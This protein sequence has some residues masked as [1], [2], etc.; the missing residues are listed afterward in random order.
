MICDVARLLSDGLIFF[1]NLFICYVCYLP[2]E[3]A[4]CSLLNGAVHD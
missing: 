3:F 4:V 2:A 1:R